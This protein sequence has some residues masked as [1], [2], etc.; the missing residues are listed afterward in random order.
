MPAL[1]VRENARSL[2]TGGG[3]LWLALLA[4]GCA[5][6]VNAPGSDSPAATAPAAVEASVEPTVAA[7]PPDTP[8][9]DAT[10]Q[11]ALLAAQA[12]EAL[13]SLEERVQALEL[14]VSKLVANKESAGREAELSAAVTDLS[15]MSG[16]LALVEGGFAIWD[17]T[18]R[19]DRAQR[20]TA[21][22]DKL[23]ASLDRL[24]EVPGMTE[25]TAAEQLVK[26]KADIAAAAA[27]VAASAGAAGAAPA[28]AGTATP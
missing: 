16:Q 20:A 9:P 17:E 14:R 4:A 26:L 21:V 13:V 15:H 18:T 24:G 1:P 19:Q 8:T 11:A 2:L 28:P 25:G 22:I 7:P 5:T 6:T 23:L 12:E 10:A 27:A 3:L